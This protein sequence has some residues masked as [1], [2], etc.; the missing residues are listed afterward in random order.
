MYFNKIDFSKKVTL[1]KDEFC[2]SF[3]AS[4]RSYIHF[5][6]PFTHNEVHEFDPYF[7]RTTVTT[8]PNTLISLSLYLIWSYPELSTAAYEYH[9]PCTTFFRSVTFA[10]I[11][12]TIT[13]PSCCSVQHTLSHYHKIA[14]C[15]TTQSYIA[16]CLE[17]TQAVSQPMVSICHDCHSH[18]SQSHIFLLIS[19]F[20][21]KL[22][23]HF[24]WCTSLVSH[25]IMCD[26]SYISII[27]H[28]V[29]H[30]RTTL[31]FYS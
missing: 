4:S 21:V 19:Y 16:L 12:A 26:A 20:P 8:A 18:N 5:P 27:Y 6:G 22:T 25:T 30:L 28:C 15:C 31:S 14:L 10:T 11:L 3:P 24:I 13:H 9:L 2:H 23:Y 17:N 1:S 29:E 7:S